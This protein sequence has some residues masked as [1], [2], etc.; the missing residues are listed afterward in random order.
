MVFIFPKLYA[1]TVVCYR[2][3]H[4]V[5]F[6]GWHFVWIIAVEKYEFCPFF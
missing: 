5:V 3:Y 2:T 4:D 6:M 1:Y